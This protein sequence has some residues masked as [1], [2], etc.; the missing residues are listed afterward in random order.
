LIIEKFRVFSCNTIGNKVNFLR[1]K[2]VIDANHIKALG[3]SDR[4]HSWGWGRG[5]RRREFF[6][7]YFASPNIPKGPH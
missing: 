7:R 4:P 2:S 5:K 6:H 1:E 3:R